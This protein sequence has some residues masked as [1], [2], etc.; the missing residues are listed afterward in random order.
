MQRLLW[1]VL[2]AGCGGGDSSNVDAAGGSDGGVD[3]FGDSAVPLDLDL[4]S[5]MLTEGGRFA[6]ANTCNGPSNVS[7]Q[8]DWTNVGSPSYAVVLTDTSNNLIHWVI[9]DIPGTASGLPADVDKTF[10]PAD[11]VGAHQTASF[12]AATRG[13]L[14]PC[15]PNLHTYEFAAFAL[16]VATLPGASMG[17]T[18]EQAKAL[19]T[20]HIVGIGTLTGQYEQP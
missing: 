7:P 11:V 15:P 20:Q 18:R 9:Y 13:Y 8:L 14:G 2:V 16:D 10:A 12:Q 4:S 17:T 5:P 6:T 3:S 19:I 1:I